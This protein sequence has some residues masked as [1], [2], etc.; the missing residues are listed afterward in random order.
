[1]TPVDKSG[2]AAAV[3]LPA[4]QI[5]ARTGAPRAGGAGSLLRVVM[6]LV[7]R[8]LL[9]LLVLGVLA[10]FGFA[11]R[12]S[13]GPVDVTWLV[14]TVTPLKLGGGDDAHGGHRAPLGR[15]EIGR[16]QL[17]WNGLHEGT[18][19][20]VLL[21][22]EDV[23]IRRNDGVIVDHMD[24]TRISLAAARLLRGQLAVT[25]IGVEGARLHLARDSENGLN[26]GLGPPHS[27]Q[28]GGSSG[29]S[30]NWSVLS[31]V[32]VSDMQLTVHDLEV[33]QDWSIRDVEIDLAPGPTRPGDEE[34]ATDTRGI[35][36]QFQAALL[37][38]GHR[39]LLR[40]H[41]IV[42]PSGAS[43]AAPGDVVWH[44][45]LDSVVPSELAAALPVLAPLRSLALPL[46][47]VLDVTFANGPGRFMEPVRATAWMM[48]GHGEI[49]QGSDRL[50]VGSGMVRLDADLPDSLDGGLQLQLS[51]AELRLRDAQDQD[52]AAS[53]PEFSAHG[54]LTLDRLDDAQHIRAVL[55]VDAP[56]IGFD[57][58]RQYW[59][60]SAAVGARRWITANITTGEAR[61]LHVESRLASDQGW[62]ALAET[63]RSGGF[64]ADGLTLWWLRP[65]APLQDMQARL[66]FQ[67]PDALLVASPHAVM[68]V[69]MPVQKATGKVTGKGA[70]VVTHRIAVSNGSMR[71]T[72]LEAQD[73]IATIGAHLSGD[74]G[75]LLAELANPRLRLLSQHPLSFSNPSGHSETDF[76]LVLPLDDKVKVEQLQ[77]TAHSQMTG[78]HLGDVAA[79]RSL[80][81]ARLSLSATTDGMS[82]AGTGQIGGIATTLQYGM[83]F[84]AG[85]PS[86]I[87]EQAHADGVVTTEAL[88]REGLDPSG[89]VDGSGHLT[90][91]YQA[92]RDGHSTISLGLDLTD[93]EV[94]TQVWA[95]PRGQ[96][97]A[98][99]AVIGLEHGKLVAIDRIHA[100]GPGLAVDARAA[101]SAGRARQVVVGHFMLGRS[102][103]AGRVDLPAPASA[104][105]PAAPIRVSAQGPVLDLSALVGGTRAVL[106]RESVPTERGPTEPGP[107]EP[108]PKQSRHAV[109]QPSPHRPPPSASPQPW[110]ADLEFGRVYISHATSLSGVSAYLQDDGRR[111]EQAQIDATGPTALSVRL[112]PQ[113]GGRHLAGT[114][115][116][117]GAALR[118]LGVTNALS[119][120]VLR[121]DA[122]VDDAMRLDGS[123]EIGRFVVLDAPLA[124]RIVRNL[125]IY[126]WLGALPSPQLAVDRLVAPFTLRDQVVT[127]TD[128]EAHSSSLGVTLHGPIDL[129]RQSLDLKGT[130]VPA[131]AVNQLPGRLPVVGH[132]FSPEKGGGVLA[133]TL[134]I[135]GPF[136]G[137]DVNVNALAALAPGILRRLLFE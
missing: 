134:T 128:A 113:N 95:K 111:I 127:L 42:P 29:P 126:G 5:P 62:G 129:G 12:L 59:P 32:Q 25:E 10:V 40:G 7:V 52:L 109:G 43:A 49:R 16:A 120:G 135:K 89:N 57:G 124:A 93:L 73:Q 54:G 80:D 112:A 2:Q 4:L 1:M 68:P 75:D 88:Q 35:V 106:P 47:P 18:T 119:G 33:G 114:A 98:A 115:A 15:L 41:G 91:G 96:P 8:P 97:A 3:A 51:R 34:A 132:L 67:G 13:A 58:L 71:I 60:S 78:V 14:H 94:S 102:S 72:G 81:D 85:P 61:N 53:G 39:A 27:R 23:S 20:P 76:T 11:L 69:V 26:L 22:L 107:T 28:S 21:R 92:Q 24:R 19:M 90:V 44:V 110:V 63:G 37:M 77:V 101:V 30:L 48:L 118:A 9:A 131:W 55:D 125:S 17:S 74:L 70:P 87:T 86:Q 46:A 79:G 50:R 6:R 108:G 56:R 65:I 116:D 38:G 66:T 104:P 117:T 83:D 133:A 137:P 121:L 105:G 136:A 122:Q 64:D 31:R 36:G 130:V 99:S 84:R 103:G 45:R 123:V 82:L 100:T